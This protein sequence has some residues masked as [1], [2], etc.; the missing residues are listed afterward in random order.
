MGLTPSLFLNISPAE[1]LSWREMLHASLAYNKSFLVFFGVFFSPDGTLFQMYYSPAMSVALCH[2]SDLSGSRYVCLGAIKSNQHFDLCDICI[3]G[4]KLRPDSSQPTASSPDPAEHELRE[5]YHSS[6][7]IFQIR[8]ADCFK[9][10]A[11]RNSSHAPGQ[12]RLG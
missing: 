4:T 11:S 2:G 7:I 12:A 6:W 1:V 9:I 5:S 10:S 8:K 3:C